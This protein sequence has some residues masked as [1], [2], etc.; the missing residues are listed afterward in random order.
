MW[1]N[2]STASAD[3][4]PSATP[5]RLVEGGED[6]VVARGIGDDRD[7]G[8]VLR[9][10]PDQRRPA[11]VDLLDQLVEGRCPGAPRRRRTGRGSRRR[12]RTAR[13]PR[14]RAPRGG[15]AGGGR[16]GRPR[17]S[18]DGA[19]SRARRAS[20][21]K[22]VTALTSVTGRPGLAQRPRRAAG[23]DELEAAADEPAAELGEPGLVADREQ[24]PARDAASAGRRRPSRAARG[25]GPGE[26]R[27]RAAAA[28]ARRRGSARAGSPRRRR[29]AI[30]TASW[31]R[32]GRRRAW[33]RRGGPCSP[34]RGRRAPARRARR[35][36][37][38][39]PAGA[40]GAC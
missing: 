32:S 19:S 23:R 8:V 25:D 18:P 28:G 5:R 20:P 38:G 4:S 36:R 26:Q 14:R 30:A 27:R 22:P 33:H 11:D 24:R 31:A 34:S 7:A 10:R 12:A 39:T 37:P 40:T 17:G 15:P 1:R 35:A 2:A 9:G 6:R 21:A 3:R 13:S 29:A 16:R